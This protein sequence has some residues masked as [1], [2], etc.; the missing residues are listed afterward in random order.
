MPALNLEIRTMPTPNLE[1]DLE[2]PRMISIKDP[3]T[4]QACAAET[5]MIKTLTPEQADRVLPLYRIGKI[6]D[7]WW[8]GRGL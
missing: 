6:V 1:T 7:S 2:L 5:E 4:L 3:V 8:H